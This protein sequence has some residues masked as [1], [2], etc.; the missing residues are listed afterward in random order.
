MQSRLERIEDKLDELSN[1]VSSFCAESK[2]D[3]SVLN[4]SVA[5]HEETIYGDGNGKEGLRVRIDRLEQSE[6]GRKFWV[7][8]AIGAGI[9]AAI[10]GLANLFHGTKP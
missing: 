4:R 2:Q 9:T 8:T 1:V 10:T 5:K 3:R 6:A 7:M